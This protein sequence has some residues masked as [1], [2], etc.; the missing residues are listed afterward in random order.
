MSDEHKNQYIIDVP[1][2]SSLVKIQDTTVVPSELDKRG[3]VKWANTGLPNTYH[4]M[5]LW[6]L[7]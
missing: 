7:S 2:S 4:I 6:K 5:K 1:P 3:K